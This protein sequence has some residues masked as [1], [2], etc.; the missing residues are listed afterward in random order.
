MGI[1][2]QGSP[3]T[4]YWGNEVKDGTVR[5]NCHDCDS[6]WDNQTTSPVGSFPPNAFGLYDM[7]GNAWQWVLDCV[8]GG[9]D[10]D[11]KRTPTDGCAWLYPLCPRHYLR[12]GNYQR[13]PRNIRPAAR[14]PASTTEQSIYV[15]FRVARDFDEPRAAD[16]KDSGNAA[17][18]AISAGRKACPIDQPPPELIVE[19]AK[20][21]A[22]K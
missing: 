12:G 21:S 4:F 8:N 6:R 1:R 22:A 20:A 10:G 9:G 13:P 14:L 17:S 11:Y 7:A 15:G 19:K 2:G 3:K 16:Q 5:A 18:E